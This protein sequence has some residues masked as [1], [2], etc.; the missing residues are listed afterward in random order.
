MADDDAE[1]VALIDN[2]LDE[3]RRTALK[4]AEQPSWR[5]WRR[6]MGCETPARQA[7]DEPMVAPARAASATLRTY[8][9]WRLKT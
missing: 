7:T 1:L 5:V 6:T 3:S 2:E 4:A 8:V 9:L